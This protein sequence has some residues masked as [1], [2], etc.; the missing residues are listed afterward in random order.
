MSEGFRE[1]DLYPPIKAFLEGQ[2]YDVKAE[3]GACDVVACRG[4]EPP[5]IVELKTRFTLDLVLQATDRQ[6]LSDQV[7]VAVPLGPPGAA[8]RGR[9]AA[10][11]KRLCRQLG[12]GLIVVDGTAVEVRCDPA[13]YRPKPQPKRRHRLLREHAERV[14]DPNVGGTSRRTIMTV[15]RQQAI[16][17]LHY[18]AATPGAAPRAVRDATGVARAAT[19]LQ[20]NHYGW[21]ERRARASY[22]LSP[23][24]Q[25]A[26]EQCQPA[27]KGPHSTRPQ[28]ASRENASSTA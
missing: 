19:I 25:A 3:I 24:G 18:V 4:A 10:R 27:K 7:Y 14:G 12:L 22:I 6:R 26:L 17:C 15:Y 28:L 23:K 1:T 13:P 16:Q 2:G 20:H 21:F 5:V 9:R 11:L 8:M